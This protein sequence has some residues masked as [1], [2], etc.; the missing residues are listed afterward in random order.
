MKTALSRRRL[1]LILL[2]TGLGV[3]FFSLYMLLLAVGYMERGMVGSSLLTVLVGFTLLSSSLY[4]LRL[5]TYVHAVERKAE[6]K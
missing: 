2:I 5:S 3:L 4:L 1:E 6:E